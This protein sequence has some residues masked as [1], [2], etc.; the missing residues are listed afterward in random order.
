VEASARPGQDRGSPAGG[1]RP[2][3]YARS[4]LIADGWD[5]V[6]IAKRIG[7]RLET[8]LGTYSH[9]FDAKRRSV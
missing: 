2:L 7:D 8:V 3:A 1:S 4:G 6:E 9:E 5:V